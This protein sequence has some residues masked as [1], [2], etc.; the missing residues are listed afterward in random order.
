[1]QDILQILIQ[2]MLGIALSAVCGYRI[3]VPFLAMGIAG[4]A[5]YIHFAD[6]F[7]WI[8]SWPAL[9]VF[10]VA[11]IVEIAA[12]FIPHLDNILN[13]I[14]LPAGAVAG[15][16]V[17]ASVISDMD[18]MLKWTLAIIAGGG[19]ATVTGLLSN[20]AHQLSTAV[21]AGFANPVVSAAESVGTVAASAI[22]IA[23]PVVG[24]AL[25]IVVVVVSV[26]IIRR[27]RKRK[28]VAATNDARRG[29]S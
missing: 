19:A 13:A 17:A 9:L 20:G 1:M 28:K 8:S 11:T 26:L 22:S 18:P 4:M 14:A 5:G 2:V 27:F 29:S 12:Y 6:G 15:A 21:S 24:V 16:I 25:F 7:T 23:M 3:F 10:G